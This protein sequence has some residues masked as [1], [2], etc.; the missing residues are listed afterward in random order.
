MKRSLQTDKERARSGTLVGMA[1]AVFIV[2]VLVPAFIGVVRTLQIGFNNMAAAERIAR[3]S[4][5]VLWATALALGLST[6]ALIVL[7]IMQARLHRMPFAGIAMGVLAAIATY[8]N[9]YVI[10]S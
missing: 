2:G 4:D 7:A 3:G 8:L 6:V 5:P 9:W 1:L 10:V